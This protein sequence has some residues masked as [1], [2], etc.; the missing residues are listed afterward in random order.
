MP[1]FMTDAQRTPGTFG[2][3]FEPDAGWLAKQPHEEALEPELPII[4]THH[5]LWDLPGS[6]Y[7]ISELAD[8]MRTG[9]NI[10]QTVFLECHA[11]YREDGP[12]EMRPV[13]ETTFA[14][15]LAAMSESGNYGPARVAQGIVGMAD[16][17]LGDAVRP[18]LE[19]HIRAGDGRFRGV[20]YATAWDASEVI[21]NSYTADGPHMLARPRVRAGI[22]CLA[23]LG[24]SYDAWVFHPQLGD[25]IELA[26]AMPDLNIVLGHCG[27][28]LGYGPYAN[29]REAVFAEWKPKMIELAAL[30]NVTVKLG[31]MMMRL[32]AFDYNVVPAPP[33]SV[34]LAEMWRPYIETCIEL[35][36]AERCMFESN[37]PVEKMG[38]S[39]VTLWNCFKRI[40][41]A[42]SASEKASLYSDTAR[43][44]YRLG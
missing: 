43:R 5:H 32:A 13:G 8:D 26:R 21:G 9:H 44:V 10:V 25:V 15:G 33:S 37:F 23:S 35:F 2:R 38:S 29:R 20:R 3:I 24:L 31:G 28:P 16:L 18:V 30:P 11:M 42:A 34:E 27:G 4:D 19:A 22:A 41:A 39:Y 7:L 40:T 6:R 14:A 12:P 1:L 36:G 17:S